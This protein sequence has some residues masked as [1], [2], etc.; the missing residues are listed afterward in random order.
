MAKRNDV[1]PCQLRKNK[2]R[3]FHHL[4]GGKDPPIE[5]IQHSMDVECWENPQ[6]KSKEIKYTVTK[7]M[8]LAQ[9]CCF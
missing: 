9:P 1:M 6:M 7:W 2:V 3:P 4:M 5:I 8:L